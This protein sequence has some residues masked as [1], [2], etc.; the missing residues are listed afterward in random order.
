[1]E[2]RNRF[3]TSP[4]R[5]LLNGNGIGLPSCGEQMPR[6]IMVDSMGQGGEDGGGGMLYNTG[7]LNAFNN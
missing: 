2:H 1:M 3:V 4:P 6:D 7:M 5:G